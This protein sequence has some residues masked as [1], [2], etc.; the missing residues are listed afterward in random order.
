M[1]KKNVMAT[2]S[3]TLKVPVSVLSPDAIKE[4]FQLPEKKILTEQVAIEKFM[5]AITTP[6][7][8]TSKTTTEILRKAIMDAVHSPRLRAVVAIFFTRQTVSVKII[9]PVRNR[10]SYNEING[11]L[12][13]IHEKLVQSPFQDIE[14]FAEENAT[15]MLAGSDFADPL[16]DNLMDDKFETVMVLNVFHDY[17]RISHNIVDPTYALL[18]TMYIMGKKE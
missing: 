5:C 2:G 14:Y 12:L 7:S 16:L 1:P 17:V 13:L 18:Q 10:L 6:P 9:H 8:P 11:L 3:K 15:H 4:L